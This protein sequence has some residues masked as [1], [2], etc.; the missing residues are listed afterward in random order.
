V[1][2]IEWG[3]SLLLGVA[4]IDE[5]HQ[6]L[7]GLI[8]RLHEVNAT[9][10]SQAEMDAIFADLMAYTKVH[11]ATEEELMRRHSY[12]GLAEHQTEHRRFIKVLG[13]FQ[14]Q[15]QK[16]HRGVIAVMLRFLREWLA[17]HIPETDKLLTVSL[18][19]VGV[20]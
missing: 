1:P 15:Y 4:E 11:F 2:L 12:P 7:V 19:A 9:E 18:N 8:N 20:R 13:E 3:P 14:V 10:P 16:G 17:H 6:G 5:Q